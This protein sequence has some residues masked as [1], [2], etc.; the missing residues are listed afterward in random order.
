MRLLGAL[1]MRFPV[2]PLL[3]V[4]LVPVFGLP[5]D[6]CRPGCR[7]GWSRGACGVR[8]LRGGWGVESAGGVRWGDWVGIGVRWSWLGGLHR[9]GG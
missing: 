5:D 9:R 2:L 4:H 6:F 8:G 3:S 7:R 1:L